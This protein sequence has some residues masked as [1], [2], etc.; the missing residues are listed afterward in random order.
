M[1]LLLGNEMEA[2]IMMLLLGLLNKENFM[3]L[4]QKLMEK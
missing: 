2:I 1:Y 3:Q 4:G